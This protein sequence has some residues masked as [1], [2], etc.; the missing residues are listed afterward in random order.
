ML[1]HTVEENGMQTGAPVPSLQSLSALFWINLGGLALSLS[2][3]L[4]LTLLPGRA[5]IQ[6]LFQHTTYYFLLVICLWWGLSFWRAGL[7][8]FRNG[9]KKHGVALVGA[10]VAVGIIFQISPVQ[11]KVLTDEAS[12]VGVSKMF[13]EHRLC[14][15]PERSQLTAQN[16]LKIKTTPSKRPPLFAFLLALV[17]GLK[18]YSSTNGFI[19]NFGLGVLFLWALYGTAYQQWGGG[20]GWTALLLAAAA[21]ILW[22]YVTASGFEVLNALLVVL[23]FFFFIRYQRHPCHP[24]DQSSILLLTMCLL[25]YGR[26]ESLL[27]VLALAIMGGGAM[28]RDLMDRRLNLALMAAPLLMLPA[29]WQRRYFLGVPEVNRVAL[30]VYQGLANPFGWR[31]LMANLDDNLFVLLGLNPHYG[32]SP[33]TAGLALI[34]TYTLSRK[35][36]FKRLPAA[37]RRLW[38]GQFT[39]GCLLLGIIS[40]FFWGRF[41]LAM[42]NR[43]ALVFLPFLVWPAAYVVGGLVAGNRSGQRWA[44]GILLLGHVAA[45]AVFAQPQ[46]LVR[47]MALPFQHQAVKLL[48]EKQSPQ[49]QK[50]LVVDQHPNLYVIDDY[51]AISFDQLAREARRWL[52]GHAW[53]QILAI[54]KIEPA[55]RTVMT[56]YGLPAGLQC[57]MAGVVPVSTEFHVQLS[58]CRVGNG[59]SPDHGPP[60]S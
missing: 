11:F 54:Q 30:D 31:N 23:L 4:A 5:T 52:G 27:L 57:R 49:P 50:T 51:H 59:E 56:G 41:T 14:V 17:H 10:F 7:V 8:T 6:T 34:G 47:N 40:S 42:D 37:Q 58:A 53:Q 13:Q 1:K 55:T 20:A 21:P 60:A 26:Y 25:A 29:L 16:E 28:L 43:L 48:L 46:R 18:G 44:V 24:G 19:L 15:I 2:L 12:L 9:I 33:L 38:V 22:V 36:L 39:A 32:F 35:V 3:T 45:A